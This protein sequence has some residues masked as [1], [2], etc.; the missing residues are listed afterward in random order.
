MYSKDVV[1]LLPV[2]SVVT[3]SRRIPYANRSF[4]IRKHRRLMPSVQ[5]GSIENHL[6]ER[7]LAVL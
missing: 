5:I 3:F 2:K 4:S 7:I 1:V 6:I